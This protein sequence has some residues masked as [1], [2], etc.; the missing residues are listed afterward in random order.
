MERRPTGSQMD[1]P[2]TD[3]RIGGETQQVHIRYWGRGNWGSERTMGEIV[4]STLC[5]AHNVLKAKA[6]HV[7]CVPFIFHTK[8]T[9]PQRPDHRGGIKQMRRTNV[10][11]IG[12]S[13]FFCLLCYYCYTQNSMCVLLGV[14]MFLACSFYLHVGCACSNAHI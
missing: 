1:E 5:Y 6:T 4:P 3:K 13:Y 11:I 10:V 8:S 14:P 7:C 2:T 12:F 9:V